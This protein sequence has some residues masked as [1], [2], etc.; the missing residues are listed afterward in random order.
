MREIIS[1]PPNPNVDTKTMEFQPNIPQNFIVAIIVFVL[2]VGI[3]MII[4]PTKS[5]KEQEQFDMLNPSDLYKATEIAD[6]NFMSY[7]TTIDGE[8]ITVYIHRRIIELIGEQPN[9]SI[10]DS[11]VL[12]KVPQQIA[13]IKKGTPFAEDIYD[14]MPAVKKIGEV[15]YSTNVKKDEQGGFYVL[16]REITEF[17][18]FSKRRLNTDYDERNK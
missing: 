4:T 9:F 14:V 15:C 10:N 1:V 12:A 3:R 16:V 7:E 5:R 18:Y 11:L 13:D 6:L 8:A 17:D 2:F